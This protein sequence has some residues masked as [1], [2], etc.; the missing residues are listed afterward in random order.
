METLAR[1]LVSGYVVGMTCMC[2]FLVKSWILVSTHKGSIAYDHEAEFNWL[3]MALVSTVV[4]LAWSFVGAGIH[5]LLRND[6][7]FVQLSMLLVLIVTLV[8]MS[9]KTKHKLDKIAMNAIVV[10]GVALLI[11]RIF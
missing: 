1:W 10:L 3:G 8:L 6:I 5:M 4:S 2:Y 9:I 11:P 7:L